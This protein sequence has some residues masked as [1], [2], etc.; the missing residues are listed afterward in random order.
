[1]KNKIGSSA[2]TNSIIK[3][4][5]FNIKKKFGQNFLIDQ[6]ILTN[7]VE[8][9]EINDSVNV[10]EIGP[11]LGSLT[12]HLAAKAHKVLCYEIDAELIPILKN[13]LQSFNNITIINQDVL[14]SDVVKDIQ[15]VFNDNRSVYLVANLPYYITTPIILGLLEKT[16]LI[17]R[18]V[19]MMQNEVALRICSK[20]DVKDYNALSIAIQYRATAKKVMDVSAN[21]FVPK[22][23]VDSAV[24]RLDLY[25]EMPYKA[26]N[27]AFFFSLIRKAFT[28]RR[29]TL[30][31]NLADEV[32]SK[33][34]IYQL[35]EQLGISKN[36]RSECLSVAD[37][38][39]LS[40]L[41]CEIGNIK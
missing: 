15:T 17:C 16:N 4:N 3:E 7:I 10:I 5:H 19:M 34:Q 18:Y 39:R 25:D 30:A 1:M 28:Q 36:A 2:T 9:S 26:C 24:I 33:E 27:E 31:N 29:K 32:F 41:M 8:A 21:V 14:K 6:N 40:D 37:F 22:P 35:L 23:M 11:G 13:N 38:V 20:P 12:E